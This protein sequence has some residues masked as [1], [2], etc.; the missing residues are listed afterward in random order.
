MSDSRALADAL[1]FPYLNHAASMFEE[2]YAS[3]E[4]V[5]NGMR[6]GCGLP[7]GPLTVIDELGLESV[8]DALAARFA[9]T[10]DPRHQPNPA[11]ERLISEG[12]TGKA[13]GKGFYT[14]EGD[15]V[16]DDELTP[17][18]T[19]R[20]DARPIKTVGVV[21]SGTM[22][23]GMIEV[24]AA[25]GFPVTYIA[26][27]RDKID[28]VAAKIAKNLGRQ[29]TKGRL[30]QGDADAILGRLTGSTEREALGD[31]DIVVEAI[32]EE[33]GIKN[34]LFADP[35]PHL[36]ARRRARHDHLVA[37][38]RRPRGA[39]QA[40]AG[41]RR[42]ALLQPGTG[43]EARRGHQPPEHRPGRPRHRPGPVPQHPARSPSAA[44]TAPAS[45]STRCSSP[46][47]T[48]PS[49]RTRTAPSWTS[50][51]AP[52]PSTTATRW[53]PSRSSTS[54]AT[55]WPRPSRRSCSP[56]SSTSP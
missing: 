32:A 51:T 40:P 20:G 13:A 31:V 7:K 55:T 27:S 33:I 52:S 23:T 42:H 4:D 43:D 38:H 45:S 49:R 47:S 46:T 9:E 41:R 35:G 16:V 11:I 21:G 19:G 30:E 15:E 44:P 8:R 2:K 29:V 10:G 17:A 54:S 22:A 48:T 56:S 34:Q 39:D 50:S 12:R 1:V 5:D 26:R 53:V 18:K 36:Q 28:A 25:N 37:V 24:F 6:F 14:Y 3:R